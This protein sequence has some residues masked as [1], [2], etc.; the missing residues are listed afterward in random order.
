MTLIT[1]TGKVFNIS[2]IG[3]SDIDGKLR[4]SVKNSSFTELFPVF[5]NP[6][7]TEKLSCVWDYDPEEDQQKIVYEYEGYTTLS[8]FLVRQDQ[9]LTVILSKE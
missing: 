5:G 2:W 8:G 3:V 1:N 4:F 9:E 6:E 7:E